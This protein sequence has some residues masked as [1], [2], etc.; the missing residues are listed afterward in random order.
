MQKLAW[1]VAVLAAISC[2]PS[3][4]RAAPATLAPAAAKTDPA[5]PAEARPGDGKP[6]ELK[7][8]EKTSKG[9]VTIGGRRI[10]YIAVAGTLVVHPKEPEDNPLEPA[11]GGAERGDKGEKPVP[12]AAA[13][14]YVAYFGAGADTARPIM[15][16]Y[17]GGP[18]SSTVWLHMGAFGPRRVVTAD[19]SHTPAAPYSVVNNEF[20]LLAASPVKVTAGTISAYLAIR[21]APS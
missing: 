19:S 3:L 17:N 1:S 14:S 4:A 6:D 8:E 11:M 10:D 12:P 15:F 2:T 18:G 21:A 20:S 16:L 13:M 5:K 9:A 7:P